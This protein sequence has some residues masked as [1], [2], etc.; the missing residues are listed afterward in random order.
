LLSRVRL[1]IGRFREFNLCVN[2]EKCVVGVTSVMF[3]GRVVSEAGI[4]LDSAKVDGPVFARFWGW[5][6]ISETLLLG[7]L[8]KWPHGGVAV[9]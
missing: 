6:K 8:E 3:L 2:P 9:S 4:R 5:R 1:L 7:S